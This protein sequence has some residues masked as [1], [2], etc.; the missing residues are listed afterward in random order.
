MTRSRNPALT[1][2]LATPRSLNSTTSQTIRFSQPAQLTDVASPKKSLFKRPATSLGTT[3][4]NATFEENDASF[5]A[6]FSYLPDAVEEA[7]PIHQP[8]AVDSSHVDVPVRPDSLKLGVDILSRFPSSRTCKALLRALGP[9]DDL[10]TSPKQIR[11][12]L[13]TFWDS[14][15]AKMQGAPRQEDFERIATDLCRNNTHDLHITEDC[16]WFHW[17]GGPDLRWEMI[18]ILIAFFGLAFYCSQEWDHV[19]KLPEQQG[20]NRN[21]AALFMKNCAEDCL[22]MCTQTN[23]NDIVVV[24]VK[25]IGRLESVL[26]GDDSE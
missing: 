23:T 2:A 12:C 3:E 8:F 20:R 22:K 19:F 24:L 26:I 14:Y 13:T 10:W 5:G 16:E 6:E 4:F 18:G 17:F 25:N 9:Y 1:K 11:H 15:G 21:S 7:R